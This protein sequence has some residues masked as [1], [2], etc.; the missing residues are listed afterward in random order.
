MKKILLVLLAVIAVTA[1]VACDNGTPAD[2][3]QHH[4]G[5]YSVYGDP[6]TDPN[7]ALV[8]ELTGVKTK[9]SMLPKD[10]AD[11]KLNLDISGGTKYTSMTLLPS[12]FY[13]LSSRNTLLDLTDLIEEHGPNIK[14]A[15][16]EQKYWDTASIDG[17]I[18]GIPQL[19]A[20]TNMGYSIFARKDI[21]D[22]HGLSVPKTTAELK[23]TLLALKG[24][25]DIPMVLTSPTITVPIRA[26][27]GVGNDWV[28]SGDEIKHWTQ[29]DGFTQYSDYLKDLNANGLLQ[30]QF[31]TNPTAI[32]QNTFF[33]TGKTAFIVSAW[34]TGNA[35][36]TGIAAANGY[37]TDDQADMDRFMSKIDEYVAYVPTLTGPND[38]KET[39]LNQSVAYFISIPK[40][41]KD[42]AVKTTKWVDAKL[43]VENHKKIAIGVE[44]T[45]HTVTDG[46]YYPILT[47]VTDGKT[48]FD[49]KTSADWFMTG[50]DTKLYGEYW[51]ARAR[52][53]KTQEHSWSTINAPENYVNVVYDALGLAPGFESWTKIQGAVAQQLAEY[54][55]LFVHNNQTFTLAKLQE[56][57]R[58]A[59]LDKA[60]KDINDWAK[61]NK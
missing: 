24:K 11:T 22:Q 33:T 57:L 20:S 54:Y 26:A 31:L 38:Y 35:I 5:Q 27:F 46:K 17:K 8:E 7:G 30:E 12:Q 14:K 42:A 49:E 50:I 51:G 39:P 1:L 6:N 16:S 18:Y 10:N 61:A 32:N 34:W 43:Q 36:Y 58:T 60:Q 9:Y 59:G 52:K 21:L 3:E 29:T 2:V 19:Q 48:P 4:L 23:A 56:N 15:I 55:P 28:K 47:P 25:I 40:Y 44:G 37:K 41:M 53:L 13:S 45:H